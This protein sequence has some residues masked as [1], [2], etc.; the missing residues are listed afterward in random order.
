MN[1]ASVTY[2]TRLSSLTDMQL[3]SQKKKEAGTEKIFKKIVAK[4]FQI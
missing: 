1:R 3:E 4:I 2:I